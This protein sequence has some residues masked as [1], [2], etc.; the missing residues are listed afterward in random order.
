MRSRWTRR[1]LF[2]AGLALAATAAAAAC[3]SQR[4]TAAP[5]KG[6]GKRPQRLTL[7]WWTDT[8]YPSPFAFS[9]VG[10]GGI[11]KL[12]LLFDSLTWKDQHGIIPWLASSWSIQDD[13]QTIVFHLRPGAAWQDGQPVTAQDVAFSFSYFAQHPFS[14]ADTS[15]VESASAVDAQTV[16]V[17]LAHPF[18]PFLE[19]V[20]GVAPVIPQHIWQSVSDPLKFQGP[21]AVTGSGPYTLASYDQAQ[22]AYLFKA[23][24]RFFAGRPAF[25]ELAYAMVPTEQQPLALQQQRVDGALALD[26]DLQARF[27]K[28]PYKVLATQPFSIVRLVFN[29]DRPPLNQPA[30]RQAIAYALDRQQIA[31]RVVHGDV[32]VGSA[33]IIPPESPWY[34]AHVTQYPYDPARA[35]A[36]LDGL[37]YM[38]PAGGGL[39]RLPDGSPL[40][41]EIL[42]DPNA[43]EPGLAQSMLAQVGVGVTLASGDPKTRAARLSKF[44]YQI[45]LLSHIGV[46]GD[47]DFLRLW[48]AGHSANAFAQGDLL[49]D[50]RFTRLADEQAAEMDPQRRRQLVAQMQQILSD[51]LPTLPLYHR[52]FF[53]IYRPG[54]W[55]RWFNTWGGIM[56][57]IPLADN[58]LA[59]LA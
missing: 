33:G 1:R 59:L 39:R 40:Q 9:N 35:N 50:D 42:A 5:A 38:R 26:Y 37:G 11:V 22:G 2:G 46:G 32:I 27:Q 34:N 55:D 3:G 17:R 6:G 24:E 52:R 19:S 25:A 28:G 56:N 29:V 7:S 51:D 58:K 43:Q 18:A 47:P 48:Y 54:L 14:W 41:V 21:G 13:G 12:S 23:H 10:P 16:S 31:Q 49:H 36:L 15:V 20:A 30:F 8:G 57:G 45:G 44:D 4:G 53:W